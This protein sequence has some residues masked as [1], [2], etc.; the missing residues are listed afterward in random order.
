MALELQILA[1]L[2]NGRFHSGAELGEKLNVSRNA[3]W[4]AMSKLELMG[5]EVHRVKR[6][7]Y[8]LPVPIEL[9]DATKIQPYISHPDLGLEVLPSVTSTNDYLLTE[10]RKGYKNPRALLVEFQT[11]GRGRHQRKWESPFGRNLTFSLLW[12]FQKD[13]A[14]LSGLSVA[15]AVSIVQALQEYGIADLQLKWPNDILWREKKLSG[16]LIDLIAESHQHTQVIIGIGL[17]LLQHDPTAKWSNLELITG[18]QPERNRIAGMILNQLLINLEKFALLGLEPFLS[19]W[20][21]LDVLA[22]KQINLTTTNG[23]Q[24]VMA[25]GISDKGEL[26]YEQADKRKTALNG[27]VRFS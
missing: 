1:E 18:Q 11:A 24:Q 2:V 3:I 26:V 16:V 13:P 19:T 9:L 22:G 10:A 7:G 4:K 8:K 6:R 12:Q 21:A 14:E 25:L 5:I 27:T 17:N 20:R 23:V 15:V